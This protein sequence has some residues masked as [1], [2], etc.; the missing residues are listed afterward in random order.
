MLSRVFLAFL[1]AA[2]GLI[3]ALC[4]AETHRLTVNV[5]GAEP[6][7]GTVEITLFNSAENF[8]KKAWMQQSG[9]PNSKGQYSTI[10]ASVPNGDYAVIAVHDA[11]QNQ[12]LDNGFLGFGGEGFGYSNQAWSIFGRPGFEDAS[13]TVTE[14]TVINIELE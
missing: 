6:S 2:A 9:P 13:F 3:P 7:T 11:N 12:K 1:A 5:T 10:F 8:H 14:A 4:L